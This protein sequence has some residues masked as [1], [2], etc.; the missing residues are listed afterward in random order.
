MKE[1]LKEMK[2]SLEETKESLRKPVIKAG[3]EAYT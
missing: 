3:L 2:E 1:S